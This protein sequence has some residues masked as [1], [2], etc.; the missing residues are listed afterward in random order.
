MFE[1]V[2]MHG[3]VAAPGVLAEYGETEIPARVADARQLLAG[4]ALLE[5][6]AGQHGAIVEGRLLGMGGYGHAPASRSEERRVGKECVRTCRSRWS[7]YH[8]TNNK[9]HPQPATPHRSQH[10]PH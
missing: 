4:A 1:H 9:H 7:P 2:E 3:D 5:R 10:T 8:Q 6:R